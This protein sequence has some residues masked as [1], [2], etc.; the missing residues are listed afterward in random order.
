MSHVTAR[1]MG[2]YGYCAPEYFIAG[3]LTMKSD[4]YSYGVL[5]LELISDVALSAGSRLSEAERSLVALVSSLLYKIRKF[6]FFY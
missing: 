2:T 1:V 3:Q 5:L 4:V 6:N